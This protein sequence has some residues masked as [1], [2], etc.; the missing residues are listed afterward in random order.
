MRTLRLPKNRCS[1]ISPD[2]APATPSNRIR[3]PGFSF[4]P[5]CTNASYSARTVGVTRDGG[6]KEEAF[7]GPAARH[8]M[9]E[10]PGR[11]D[12]GVVDYQQI[13][14]PQQRWKIANMEMAH[15]LRFGDPVA[16]RRDSPR[17]S[18]SWAISS[19]GRSKWKS[20]TSISQVLRFQGSRVLKVPGSE[21]SGFSGFRVLRVLCSASHRSRGSRHHTNGR[22]DSNQMISATGAIAIRTTAAMQRMTKT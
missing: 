7:H 18:G 5:G 17:G 13:A 22:C 1:R 2:N 19:F 20:E 10:Q 21:G 3:A 12:P 8:S 11:E 15:R 4:C 14:R 9:A 6:A 16:R